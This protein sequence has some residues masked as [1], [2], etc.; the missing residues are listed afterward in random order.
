METR[1][2]IEVSQKDDVFYNQMVVTN[3][4]SALTGTDL[5]S[6]QVNGKSII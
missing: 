1:V 3:T 6:S 4:F 2:S 5:L